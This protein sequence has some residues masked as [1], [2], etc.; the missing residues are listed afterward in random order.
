MIKSAQKGDIT[1]PSNPLSIIVP[2][3]DDL[4]ARKLFGSEFS[5]RGIRKLPMAS[6]VSFAFSETQDVHMVVCHDTLS[7]GWKNAPQHLALA[8]GAF[9]HIFGKTEFATVN[10]GASEAAKS[11]H[12]EPTK[13]LAVMRESPVVLQWYEES[14]EDVPLRH[15]GRRKVA[16]LTPYAIWRCAAGVEKLRESRIIAAPAAAAHAPV[17][18]AKK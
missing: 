16:P 3:S 18:A 12:S 7:Q 6:I 17:A 2:A 9:P 10:I 1:S 5:F 4:R 13:I 8:L 15:D 11:A 14:I